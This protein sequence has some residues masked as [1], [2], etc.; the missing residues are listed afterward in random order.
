MHATF[1]VHGMHADGLMAHMPH[2]LR[3][4]ACIAHARRVR[5]KH[6]KQHWA[7]WWWWVC[8]PDRMFCIHKLCDN[9]QGGSAVLVAV[10]AETSRSASTC[11]DLSTRGAVES[12]RWQWGCAAERRCFR[13]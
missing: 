12:S 10:T 5:K 7:P 11:A 3:S 2:T 1:L 4:H 9:R 6:I 8:P 13:V